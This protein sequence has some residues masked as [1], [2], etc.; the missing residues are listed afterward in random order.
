VTVQAEDKIIVIVTK[1]LEII[2]RIPTGNVPFWKILSGNNKCTSNV[3]FIIH[4]SFILFYIIPY[5]IDTVNS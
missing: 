4:Y 1:S 5:Y 2:S 3:Y